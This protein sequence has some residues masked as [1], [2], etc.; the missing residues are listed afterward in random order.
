MGRRTG[1]ACFTVPGCG[2]TTGHGLPSATV[3]VPLERRTKRLRPNKRLK[4]AGGDR[5]LG[6][7]ECCAPDGARTDVAHACAGGR[8]ARRLKAVPLGAP[9]YAAETSSSYTRPC[10]S[11]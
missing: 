7:A 5:F 6:E 2:S 8:G 11:L 10:H 4:L 9:N 1:R 3:A